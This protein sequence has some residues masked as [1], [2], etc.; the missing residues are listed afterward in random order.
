ML[1]LKRAADSQLEWVI[2][3]KEGRPSVARN[4]DFYVSDPK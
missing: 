4:L 2:I 1:H 3:M